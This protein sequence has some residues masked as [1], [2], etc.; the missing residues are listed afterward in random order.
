MREFEMPSIEEGF[1]HVYVVN[2][3]G[4]QDWFNKRVERKF[5]DKNTKMNLIK[6]D[7]PVEDEEKKTEVFGN[8]PFR[9]ICECCGKVEILTSKEAYDKGWEEG[10]I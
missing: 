5:L 6:K 9:H 1:A 2:D 7:M 10:D 4:V 8:K 3:K